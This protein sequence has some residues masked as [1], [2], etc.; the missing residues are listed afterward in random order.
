MV[1]LPGNKLFASLFGAGLDFHCG[2]PLT[3]DAHA[4]IRDLEVGD[5]SDMESDAS[6]LQRGFNGRICENM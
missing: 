6:Q 4:D 5:L 1:T 3:K 2:L